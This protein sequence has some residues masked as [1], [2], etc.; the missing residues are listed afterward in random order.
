MLTGATFGKRAHAAAGGTDR[1]P[2]RRP[3]S[4]LIRNGVLL[5]PLWLLWLALSSTTGTC[6]TRPQQL[7]I[8]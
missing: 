7:L 5:S 1:R 3:L 4:M 2:P 8:R 6:S